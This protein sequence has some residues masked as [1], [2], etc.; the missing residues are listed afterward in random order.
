M[1]PHVNYALTVILALAS[2]TGGWSL[3]Q[4]VLTRTGR[5]AE[6]ARHQAETERIQREAEN[7]RQS[8]LSAAQIT[9][10]K[11]AL[12]S[13]EQRYK[14]LR[15]DYDSTRFVLKELRIATEALIDVMDTV[16]GQMRPQN[17]TDIVV[18]TIT[19]AEY[20]AARTAMREARH[21]L[22]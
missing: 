6:M 20:L 17:E 1:A 19:S 22:Q 7:N 11:A 14:E 5:K 12:D 21:H 13:S 16:I 18:V 15:Q 10:Q 3:L 9:A 4:F 8:I 2:G